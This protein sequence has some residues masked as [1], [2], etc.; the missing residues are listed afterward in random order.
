MEV[1]AWILQFYHV[2]LPSIEIN[3]GHKGVSIFKPNLLAVH[4]IKH[5]D[6]DQ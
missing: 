1:Y 6:Q 3:G 4:A 2:Q 5:D